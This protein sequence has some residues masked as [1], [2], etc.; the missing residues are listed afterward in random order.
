MSSTITIAVSCEDNHERMML[1]DIVGGLL[2]ER[3]FDNVKLVNRDTV[4]TLAPQYDHSDVHET[5]LDSI[6]RNNPSF[7]QR[8]VVITDRTDQDVPMFGMV[9][10]PDPQTLPKHPTVVVFHPLGQRNQALVKINEY[11]QNH[12][13]L[14]FVAS[15]QVE[16]TEENI[17]S[18]EAE[19]KERRAE[20]AGRAEE[21]VMKTLARVEDKVMDIL[22]RTAP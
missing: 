20:R 9:I 17:Y 21:N 8:P 19:A 13:N 14:H 3:G 7:F 22:A 2:V 16:L 12:P 5:L 15:P 6:K 10:D 1:T 11:R 18:E 4:T